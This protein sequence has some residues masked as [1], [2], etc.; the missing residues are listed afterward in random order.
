[1]SDRDTLKRKK[2]LEKA[3]GSVKERLIFRNL[4]IEEKEADI[5]RIIWNL[6]SA[7]RKKWPESWPN[8]I[9]SKSTGVVAFMRFLRPAYLHLTKNIGE[10][11]S[12]EQFVNLLEDVDIS[13][14]SFNKENYLP[15]SSGQSKL[16][17]ELLAKTGLE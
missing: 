15:G 13:G 17:R 10:V 2:R 7:V 11:I 3:D 9:L 12:E 16:Y 4:F 6:F 14:D 5:A 1:M 8:T